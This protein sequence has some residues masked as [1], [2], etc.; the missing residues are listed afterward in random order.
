MDQTKELNNEE[1]SAFITVWVFVFISW[2][3]RRSGN[4]DGY[5]RNCGDTRTHKYPHPRANCDLNLIANSYRYPHS[6]TDPHPDRHS[7]GDP[8]PC[9][10]GYTNS[11]RHPNTNTHS[12]LTPCHSSTRLPTR[13]RFTPFWPQLAHESWF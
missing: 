6:H 1:G 13:C 4:P 12:H 3:C 10:Y 9:A 8:I 7:D 2:L 5:S 11:H